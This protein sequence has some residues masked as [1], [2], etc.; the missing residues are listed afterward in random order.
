MMVD[1]FTIVFNNISFALQVYMQTRK[2]RLCVL[3]FRQCLWGANNTNT[4]GTA[5]YL[6]KQPQYKSAIFTVFPFFF[7]FFWRAPFAL[8]FYFGLSHSFLP[9]IPIAQWRFEREILTAIVSIGRIKI[10]HKYCYFT[11]QTLIYR[12]K[13]S[14]N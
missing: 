1:N 4:K 10:P 5:S 11:P 7:C 9:P 6:L 13:S 3:E 8:S 12:Y 2:V 14:Q